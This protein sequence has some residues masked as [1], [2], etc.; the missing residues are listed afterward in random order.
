MT[1]SSLALRSHDRSASF[2]FLWI[3][4]GSL[5]G[6]PLCTGCRRPFPFSQQRASDDED[7]PQDLDRGHGLLQEHS[8]EEQCRH[9][10]DIAQQR[11]RLSGDLLQSGEI[12][13]IGKTGIDRTK[14]HQRGDLVFL[15]DRQ[16]RG[17]KDIDQY[18]HE[19]NIQF[20]GS[21]LQ[22]TGPDDPLVKNESVA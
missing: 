15:R 21:G 18:H 22:P 7:R 11:H 5:T 17:E 10:I 1:K 4:P 20:D 13:E 16:S 14:D 3:G 12:Q 9:G 8:G 19:G 6:R 2:F